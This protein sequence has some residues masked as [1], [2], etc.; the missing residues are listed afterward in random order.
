M[1][2]P[3]RRRSR[4]KRGMGRANKNLSAPAFTECPHCHE[5]KQ[6]HRICPNCGQYGDRTFK[7]KVVQ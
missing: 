5:P 3:R 2:V 6:P 7:V 1:P 4:A